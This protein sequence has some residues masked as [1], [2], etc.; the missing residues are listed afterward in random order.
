M[1]MVGDRLNTD[2]AFGNKGGID[3][4][5]VL[6]GAC[7]PDLVGSRSLIPSSSSAGIDDRAGFE[8]EDA[9]GVPTFVV[10]S[11]GDLAVLA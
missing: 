1:I 7:Q 2:I 8:K 11:L 5:M 4:L 9:P 3:T 6:T 10:E